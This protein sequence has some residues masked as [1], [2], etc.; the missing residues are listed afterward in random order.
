MSVYFLCDHLKV[1]WREITAK[2]GENRFDKRELSEGYNFFIIFPPQ[3]PSNPSTENYSI[4]P[5]SIY[6]SLEVFQ[7]TILK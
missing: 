7:R 5:L 4:A 1:C 3:P 6:Q 2:E